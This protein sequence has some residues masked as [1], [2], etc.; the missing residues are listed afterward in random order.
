MYNQRVSK[1]RAD[2]LK[3]KPLS[4]AKQSNTLIE[5]RGASNSWNCPTTRVDIPLGYYDN[6]NVYRE[7]SRSGYRQ[8]VGRQDHSHAYGGPTD[9]HA[10]QMAWAHCGFHILSNSQRSEQRLLR[11][12]RYTIGID[13]LSCQ[14]LCQ[15]T[16]PTRHDRGGDRRERRSF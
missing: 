2:T 6:M 1:G 4:A 14:P 16:R 7:S 3:L 13:S 9:I 8:H 15:I 11:E 10:Q 5:D 12:A